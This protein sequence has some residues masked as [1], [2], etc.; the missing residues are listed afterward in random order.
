MQP[1][2]ILIGGTI[3]TIDQARPHATALAI[4]GDRITAA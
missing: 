2:V 3:H 4:A 1:D